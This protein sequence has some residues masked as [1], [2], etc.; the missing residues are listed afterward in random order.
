[1]ERRL[2][3]LAFLFVCLLS[4]PSMGYS[5]TDELPKKVKKEKRLTAD[6]PYIIKN[7]DGTCRVIS[8]DIKGN[9]IDKNYT[10]I[11]PDCTF[12]VVSHNKKH[13][14]EVSLH[15][16]TRPNWRFKQP[17][18]LFVMS[19]PHGNLDC[20]VSLLKGNNI[21]DNDYKWCYG[22]NRLVIIGDIFDRGEDVLQIMWL[23]YKLEKEAASVG[24][25]VDFLLG[26]HEAL[27]LMN[28]LRY[29]KSKYTQL[30]RK[31]GI[32]YPDLFAQKTVS[33]EWLCTRN[34]IQ[35][36][37]KYLFVHA[38][39]GQQFYDLN[40]CCPIKVGNSKNAWLEH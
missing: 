33:G 10:S 1:M 5:A 16:V 30:A 39:L 2:L 26:N 40:Y 17:D 3:Q 31:L 6:G 7:D 18:K 12:T 35:V 34:T 9:I 8:V 36:V 27:V 13:K 37:G 25:A 20:V 29:T 4:A 14:F 24:G 28:D 38:G 15:D 32:K 23:F 22:S 19:D 21:I 11:L